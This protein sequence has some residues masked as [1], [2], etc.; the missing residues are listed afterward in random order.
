MYLCKFTT[1]GHPSTEYLI[2]INIKKKKK[3]VY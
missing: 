2:P 3:T 1:K